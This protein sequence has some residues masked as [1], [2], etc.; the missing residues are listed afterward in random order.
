MKRPC[1]DD[2]VSLRPSTASL[3]HQ[4]HKLHLQPSRVGGR[5]RSLSPA[6]GTAY[7]SNHDRT[8]SQEIHI[9]YVTDRL[10]DDRRV[11]KAG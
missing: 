5:Q 6:A 10:M 3:P 11:K 4:L 8:D 2:T 7:D 1:L 9:D